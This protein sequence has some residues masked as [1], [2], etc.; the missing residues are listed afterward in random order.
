MMCTW[1][2]VYALTCPRVKDP[3]V[4]NSKSSSHTHLFTPQTV[5]RPLPSQDNKGFGIGEL[6]WGKIKGFSWWP[7]IVVTWRATGKRQ[8]THGMRW[9]QWFGDGKFSEVRIEDGSHPV[10]SQQSQ[11]S[12][13]VLAERNILDVIM[14]VIKRAIFQGQH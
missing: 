12:I 5:P 13:I 14:S 2:I 1:Q 4:S 6:V 3:P 10:Y 8:A 11:H 9:L 7:G